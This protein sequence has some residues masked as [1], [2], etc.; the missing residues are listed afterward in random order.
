MRPK[1]SVLTCPKKFVRCEFPVYY[2]ELENRAATWPARLANVKQ[3][4]VMAVIDEIRTLPQNLVLPMPTDPGL[5]EN[6]RKKCKSRIPELEV[7]SHYGARGGY[8][9]EPRSAWQRL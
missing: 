5:G 3:S 6:Q 9:S 2:E 4:H 7:P 1:T 8:I